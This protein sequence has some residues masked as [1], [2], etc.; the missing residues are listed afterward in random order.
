MLL[1]LG[2]AASVVLLTLLL[3]PIA[4]LRAGIE[5]IGGGDLTATLALRDRTEFGLLA[6]AINQMVARLRSAQSA[7]LERE[8]LAHEMELAQ[9]IQRSLLPA[10]PHSAG[11]Y[12]VERSE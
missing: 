4:T 9:Q 1:F 5:R 10:A 11:R 12:I 6:D 8:R 7:M 3:R 2:V